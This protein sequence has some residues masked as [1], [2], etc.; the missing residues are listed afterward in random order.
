MTLIDPSSPLD[1]K[2][3]PVDTDPT[4]AYGAP[5]SIR[6]GVPIITAPTPAFFFDDVVIQDGL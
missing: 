3:T 1:P 4:F 5:Y 6:L 2:V